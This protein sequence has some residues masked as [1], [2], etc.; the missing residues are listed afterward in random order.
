MEVR[1]H[2]VCIEA[3]F[4]EGGCVSLYSTDGSLTRYAAANKVKGSNN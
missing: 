1:P 3:S 4:D 2:R